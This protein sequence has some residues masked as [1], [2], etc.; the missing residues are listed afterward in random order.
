MLTSIKLTE[1]EGERE[2]EARSPLE[3]FHSINSKRTLRWRV[4]SLV[5]EVLRFGDGAGRVAMGG[6][7]PL[8]GAACFHRRTGTSIAN[9]RWKTR[10]NIRS[11]ISLAKNKFC[12]G[13]TPVS[14]ITLS[15]VP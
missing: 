14:E 12:L 4:E 15:H 3:K 1:R 5:R 7:A 10:L 11:Q 2:R 13:N 8:G 6:W 9:M